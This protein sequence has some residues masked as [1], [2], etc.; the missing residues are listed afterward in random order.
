MPHI[1]DLTNAA[2]ALT[3]A[4]TT[5]GALLDH[6]GAACVCALCIAFAAGCGAAETFT[7]LAALVELGARDEWEQHRARTPYR[8]LLK[9]CL[10]G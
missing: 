6:H 9:V 8:D 2:A 7:N 4:L 10:A 3:S 1:G 5:L